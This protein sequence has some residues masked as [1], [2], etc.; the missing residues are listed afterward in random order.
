MDLSSLLH[1][2]CIYRVKCGIFIIFQGG[3]QS[4]KEAYSSGMQET[5]VYPIQ[6]PGL[7]AAEVRCDMTSSSG[8][9]TVF[10]RRVDAT[11][12]FNRGWDDYKTGFGDPNGNFWLGLERLHRLASPDNGAMLRIDLQDAS[13][14]VMYHAMYTSFEISDEADGYRIAVG[15]YS[16]TVTDGLQYHNGMKFST[17]DQDNDKHATRNCAK[18]RKGGWWFNA[19][20]T[21]HLNGRHPSAAGVDDVKELMCWNHPIF[22]FGSWSMSEMKLKKP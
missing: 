18:K 20:F 2:D 1:L 3:F 10:Q 12:N 19:C 13:T 15:G 11:V 17:K 8:G 21:S 5:G 16:G 7:N 4:C 22:S 6:M 9:W 14:K